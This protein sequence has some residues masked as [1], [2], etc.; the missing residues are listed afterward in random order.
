VLQCCLK[1]QNSRYARHKLLQQLLL[2]LQAL[3][4][5]CT[6]GLS[7]HSITQQSSL[8]L[9][10]FLSIACRNHFLVTW[11][12]I[13]SCFSIASQQLLTHSTTTSCCCCCRCTLTRTLPLAIPAALPSC[14]CCCS[15]CCWSIARPPA[16]LLLL[17]LFLLL[18]LLLLLLLPRLLCCAC[19]LAQC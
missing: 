9:P 16:A 7:A 8:L 2:Q 6:I 17:L 10:I 14:C 13:F 12:L 11:R 18:L 3:A 1:L 15:V 4:T 5:I 19:R